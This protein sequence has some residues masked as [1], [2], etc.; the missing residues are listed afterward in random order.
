MCKGKFYIDDIFVWGSGLVEAYL[1]ESKKAIYPRIIV[2][3]DVLDDV[4]KHLRDWMI[5]RDEDGSICLNY[6]KAF[7][8]SKQGWISDINDIL[9]W[10]EP[11]YTALKNRLNEV[12]KDEKKV[13]DKLNWLIQFVYANKNFWDSYK[14]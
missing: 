8:G 6:L 1:L 14:K 10:L 12:N 5:F 11:E 3:E 4:G 13:Y 7:G 9:R 2:A